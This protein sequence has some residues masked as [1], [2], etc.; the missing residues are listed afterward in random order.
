M[1][2]YQPGIPA[3]FATATSPPSI[4]KDTELDY[5]RTCSRPGGAELGRGRLNVA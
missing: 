3:T 5:I 2:I 1:P 4:K